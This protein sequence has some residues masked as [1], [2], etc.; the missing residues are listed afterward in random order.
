V[1]ENELLADPLEEARRVV[2]AAE[3][4]DLGVRQIGGTAVR[5]HSET[6]G[7]DPFKRGYRDV[8]FVGTRE[9]ESTIIDLM[10]ELGYSSN[11]RFNTMHRYRLE[12]HDEVND[13]KADYCID[14]FR[15]CH[16]WSLR[17]RVEADYPT[18]PIEDL[19]LSKLQIVEA[20]DR[21]VRDIIAMLADHPVKPGDDPEQIDPSYIAGLTRRKWGLYN[22]VTNSLERVAAFVASNDLPIDENE[23]VDRVDHLRSAIEESSK[24][25]RWKL[26]SIIGERKQWYRRP[27]LE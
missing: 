10:E 21:D 20:S 6:A 11:N 18:I 9:E 12:F 26:R 2:E 25:I 7:V 8:D 16:E 23:L 1:S 24:T 4:R 14:K 17:D 19:L 15:F 13:R 3:E 27:E 22:T 5:A